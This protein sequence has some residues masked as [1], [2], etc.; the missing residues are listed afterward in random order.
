[1]HQ[2]GS[3]WVNR[4][5]FSGSRIG[6]GRFEKDE[7]EA[8]H[9]LRDFCH[10]SHRVHMTDHVEMNRRNWVS[11]PQFTQAIPLVIIC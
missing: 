7:G 2:N 5:P 3:V 8:G 11:A 1:M 6:S 10:M 9:S 4:P